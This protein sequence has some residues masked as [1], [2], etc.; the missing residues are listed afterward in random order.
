LSSFIFQT[1]TPFVGIS[2]LLKTS[3]LLQCHR[4]VPST[5]LDKLSNF[6]YLFYILFEIMSNAVNCKWLLFRLCTSYTR[7]LFP[8][9]SPEML[10]GKAEAIISILFLKAAAAMCRLI[11]TI[12]K[13]SLSQVSIRN[14]DRNSKKGQEFCPFAIHVPISLFPNIQFS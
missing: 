13:P 2:T 14:M 1:G 6:I 4:A 11:G 10:S 3:R 7:Q 8:N 9:Q 12:G 5:A